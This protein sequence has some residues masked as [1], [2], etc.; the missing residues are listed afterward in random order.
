M[1]LHKNV[2]HFTYDLDPGQGKTRNVAYYPHMTYEPAKFEDAMSNSL[3][4]N[5]FT[6]NI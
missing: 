3:G 4:G 1:P 5:A 6:R 2:H